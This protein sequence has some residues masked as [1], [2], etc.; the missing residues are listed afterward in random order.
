M[1]T[2]NRARVMAMAAAASFAG[3]VA[4]LGAPLKW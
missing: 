3:L 2:R 4:A 1:S